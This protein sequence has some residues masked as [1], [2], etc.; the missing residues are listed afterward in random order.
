MQNPYLTVTRIIKALEN[1][2][3]F[4]YSLLKVVK[5]SLQNILECSLG[6]HN[7]TMAQWTLDRKHQAEDGVMNTFN[8]N[9]I[10][11]VVVRENWMK[12]K[13]FMVTF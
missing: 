12:Q 2:R 9:Q 4:H 1:N 7:E 13:H 5:R 10:L 6:M 8:T 3:N 11:N